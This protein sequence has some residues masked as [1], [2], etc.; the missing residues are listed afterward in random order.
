MV[1]SW[2][3]LHARGWGRWE[4]QSSASRA[5]GLVEAERR[6]GRAAPGCPAG[7]GPP[8]FEDLGGPLDSRKPALPSGAAAAS[9]P[10]SGPRL[11]AGSEG[12][13]AC[14]APATLRGHAPTWVQTCLGQ[15]PGSLGS[16]AATQDRRVSA[17]VVKRMP[18]RDRGGPKLDG[19]A[20][21]PAISS[22]PSATFPCARLT[23]LQRRGAAPVGGA[24]LPCRCFGPPRRAGRRIVQISRGGR[25]CRGSGLRPEA[26]GSAGTGRRRRP[27]RASGCRLEL[28]ATRNGM[29]LHSASPGISLARVLQ[30]PATCNV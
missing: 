13:Q 25:A 30:H 26:A 9:L 17:R 28:R 15:R 20:V 23:P 24:S 10:R 2:G 3:T 12:K 29:H 7:H 16:G 27:E 14:A 6:A 5:P 1:P 21:S 18:Q 4:A 8:K 19:P 11:Q 22:C